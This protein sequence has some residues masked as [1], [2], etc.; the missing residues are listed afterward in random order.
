[1]ALDQ[2]LF[3]LFEEVV[4]GG[5]DGVIEQVGEE[6]YNLWKEQPFFSRALRGGAR[7][8]E[9]TANPVTVGPHAFTRGDLAV[10]NA[11][12]ACLTAV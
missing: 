1:M 5:F 6:R 7:L 10:L 12:V 4:Y 9:R 11:F 3:D 8:C 2:P